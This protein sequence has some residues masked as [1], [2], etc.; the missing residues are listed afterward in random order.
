MKGY[1][2]S[3]TR[4]FQRLDP[5]NIIGLLSVLSTLRLPK[6]PLV[7]SR[8][9]E[10]WRHF[11]HTLSFLKSIGWV[12]ENGGLL[13]LTD[14]LTSSQLAR[15]E[16][17]DISRPIVEAILQSDSGYRNALCRYL[18]Q[19]HAN[20]AAIVHS[21]AAERRVKESGVRNFLSALGMISYRRMQD[22]YVVQE[23]IVDLWIWAKGFSGPNTKAKLRARIEERERIGTGAEDVAVEYERA[24]LGKDWA[25]QIQHVARDY[26]LASYDIKSVTIS[27]GRAVPRF[28]EVKAV[29]LQSFRFFWSSEE[30]EAARLLRDAYFLYLVPTRG[31]GSFDMSEIWI[32]DNAYDNICR[33]PDQWAVQ[34]DV[35]LCQPTIDISS[36][37]R[38]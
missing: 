32:V 8:Y 5:K 14:P 18:D 29:S 2:Y 35:L 27:N 20:G 25:N 19:F 10:H 3:R 36:R 31:D 17:R 13:V 28:I 1:S 12:A 22:D 9:S 38:R 6:K 30:V 7:E 26:P 4:V 33:N 34:S 15:K 23:E 37:Q 21:P 11:E 24:R 16:S